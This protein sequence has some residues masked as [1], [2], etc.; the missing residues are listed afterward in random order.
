MPS[1]NQSSFNDRLNRMNANGGSPDF[2]SQ[3]QAPTERREKPSVGWRIL[4]VP[5]AFVWGAISL[6]A[7]DLILFNI[8]WKPG[9]NILEVFNLTSLF[10]W[11]GLILCFLFFGIFIL[12]LRGTLAVIAFL[13]SVL[14]SVIPY[15][16]VLLNVRPDLGDAIYHPEYMDQV[17]QLWTV[18]ATGPGQNRQQRPRVWS[19]Q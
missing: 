11:F 3:P 12:S 13:I 2:S 5:L 19:L 8:F 14:F 18:Q 7:I 16:H 10:A 4:R 6:I 9:I 17:R 15:Y 1:D